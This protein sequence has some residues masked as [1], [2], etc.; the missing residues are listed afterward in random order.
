MKVK[1]GIL[2]RKLRNTIVGKV[3]IEIADGGNFSG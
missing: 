2:C 3:H 1:F